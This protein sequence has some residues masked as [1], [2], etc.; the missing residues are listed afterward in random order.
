MGL[1][2]TNLIAN[3]QTDQVCEEAFGYQVATQMTQN[4]LTLQ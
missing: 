2:G 1:L 3:T 4:T